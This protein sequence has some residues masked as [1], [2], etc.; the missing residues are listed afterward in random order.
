MKVAAA[1]F[2]GLASVANAAGC[3]GGDLS[4]WMVGGT[5]ERELQIKDPNFGQITRKYV[6]SIPSSYK[7]NEKTPLWFYMHG[8]GGSG[9]ENAHYQQ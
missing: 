1:A 6:I 9:I 8:Q 7:S 3:R 5:E 2:G 4:G